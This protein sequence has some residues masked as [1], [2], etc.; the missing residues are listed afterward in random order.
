MPYF[1][2]H[3]FKVGPRSIQSA[4]MFDGSDQAAM[5]NVDF[6]VGVGH[7]KKSEIR[8]LTNIAWD[9]QWRVE[10]SLL[11]AVHQRQGPIRPANVRGELP[12]KAKDYWMLDTDEERETYYLSR[13]SIRMVDTIF[14]FYRHGHEIHNM[15][16]GQKQHV[17]QVVM[18]FL[19]N[20]RQ[21]SDN[22]PA[23]LQHRYLSTAA[24]RK[25]WAARMESAADVAETLM[26]AGVDMER[27]A[28]M[29][30]EPAK[31]LQPILKRRGAPAALV[32]S[33]RF[34]GWGATCEGIGLLFDIKHYYA[35]REHQLALNAVMPTN[36]ATIQID[37][38]G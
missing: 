13:M 31:Y 23:L 10:A 16:R 11:D 12:N 29:C 36:S 6:R 5:H 18:R 8:K 37:M 30:R 2:A 4:V 19:Q 25:L 32:K 33:S 24:D 35:I 28:R 26:N 34:G 38:E 22:R 15:L 9:A 27:I 21:M 20:R 7:D 17:T 14:P 1:F 3:G